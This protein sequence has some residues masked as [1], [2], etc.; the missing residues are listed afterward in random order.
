VSNQ[1][2]SPAWLEEHRVALAEPLTEESIVGIGHVLDEVRS[3]LGK[4]AHPELMASMG[5][6]LPRGILFYGRPGTGKTLVARYLASSLGADVP[7]YELSA[8]E[9]NPGLVRKLFDHLAASHER[10]VLYL[11]E[12]DLV[13]LDRDFATEGARKILVALLAAIDGMRS[14]SGPILVASSNRAPKQ[15]DPAL[16]RPGRIGVHIPFDLPDEE[17]RA[18]LF[19]YFL[20][21]RPRDG[22]IDLEPLAM[23]AAGMTPAEIRAIVDD[24]TGLALADGRMAITQDDLRRALRRDGLVLPEELAN[25][26]PD[27]LKRTAVHEAGHAA[28]AAVLRGPDWIQ[29]VDI[30]EENGDTTLSKPNWPR[31]YLPGAELRDAIIVGYGGIAAE[32][33]MYGSASLA[34]TSDIEKATTLACLLAQVGQLDGAGAID[35]ATIQAFTGI[36]PPDAAVS[37]IAATLA[38]ARKV[39]ADIV[40]DFHI[41]IH[42]LADTFA[43]SDGVLSGDALRTALTDAGFVGDD[44]W[45]DEPDEGAEGDEEASS[46]ELVG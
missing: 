37:I 8:D 27:K 9:L 5:A 36:A 4:L 1:T 42:A 44:D 35:Y 43:A 20:D 30:G 14:T 10:C 21:R 46:L 2:F 16:T 15:L 45:D 13:A 19:A 31:D 33:Q 28:V 3:L 17:E 7:M 18:E 11:D 25:P 22:V 12:I 29:R 6:E 41:E 34:A 24:A 39:A 32:E 26:D 38:S 23:R 40:R